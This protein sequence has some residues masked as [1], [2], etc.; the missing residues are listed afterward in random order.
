MRATFA[1]HPSGRRH[2]GE[3]S[4]SRACSR[5]RLAR[6]GRGLAARAYADTAGDA[7]TAPDITT[8][9]A[10]RGDDRAGLGRGSR[11]GNYQSLPA[12]S[13]VNLWFDLDSDQETGAAGDE[14]LVRYGSDGGVEL[15]RW[16]GA[17]LV[18]GRRQ[19]SPRRSGRRADALGTAGL[20]AAERV[21]DPR[22]HARAA[23]A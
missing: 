4:S 22:G 17:R 14:A 5:W 16:D 11:V 6:R 23:Q 20:V 15:Y 18:E 7:N 8:R 19:A 3:A 1:Q 9:R 21:R 13:W 12:A 2:V 10:V